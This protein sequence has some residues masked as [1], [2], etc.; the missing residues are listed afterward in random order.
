M[1]TYDGHVHTPFCPHGSSDSLESYVEAAIQLGYKGMTFAEH[2]P[3]PA[4]FCDPVPAQ[5]SAMTFS[6][7]NHYLEEVKLLKEQYQRHFTIRIGLEVDYIEGFEEETRSFLN[8]VGPFLDDAI[9]SV[10]FIRLADR[11]ICMDYSPE[12]FKECVLELGSVEAVYDCYFETVLKSIHA[13]LGFHKPERI[14]HVTLVRK[15]QK[16]FP[17]TF[18]YINKLK[19]IFAEMKKRNLSLDINGAGVKKPLCK[20]SYPPVEIEKLVSEYQIRCIYGSDA[21]AA[22]QLASG[23][24]IVQPFFRSK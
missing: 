6:K 16:Q 7:L 13:N 17:A 12:S 19:P 15:F 23:A 4:T 3:L 22:S 24:A 21:H 1:I 14:G 20:E 5:D 18:P 9:L 2:A 8:E 11:Y 10:H